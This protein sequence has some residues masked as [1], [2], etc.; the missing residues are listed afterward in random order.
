MTDNRLAAILA[1][2]VMGWT[3]GPERFTMRGRRWLPRWR[4]QPATRLE[5]A[6]RLLQSVA[7]Q[8]YAT[9]GDNGLFWARVRVGGNT[10]EAHEATQARAITFAVARAL[11]IEV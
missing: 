1:Q 2:R 7:A 8:E 10:A 5:D 9:G 3:V 11:G 6:F 4:F